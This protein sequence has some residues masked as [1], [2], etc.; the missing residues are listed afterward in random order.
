MSHSEGMTAIGFARDQEIGVDLERI[1]TMK[2]LEG[3]IRKSLQS[4]EIAQLGKEGEQRRKNFFR[5]WTFKESY[6]KAVGEGMR[7]SPEKLEF[8]IRKGG[9]ELIAAPYPF[10]EEVPHFWEFVPDE[11]Y[12]GTVTYRS[13]GTRILEKELK[14][15]E[16][17]RQAQEHAHGGDADL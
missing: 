13:D 14:P 2:D 1:R 4:Q 11:A 10:G 9:I 5:F 12:T 16:L 15:D 17:I 6:L 7:L 3:L 8:R